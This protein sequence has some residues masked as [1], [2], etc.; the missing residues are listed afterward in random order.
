MKADLK[1]AAYRQ[2]KR[3]LKNRNKKNIAIIFTFFLLLILS[4]LLFI[5]IKNTEEVPSS[6][7]VYTEGVVGSPRFL[8]PIYSEKN[9][10][11]NDLT[12]LLFSGLMTY[13]KENNLKPHL[14]EEVTT[15]DKITFEIKLREDIHWSDGKPITADDVIFTVEKIQDRAIQSPLRVAW[16]GVDA[17]KIDS[18]TI[19]FNL[20]SSSPL[21]FEKLTLKPIPE[22]IWSEVANDDF[23]FS[24][25]N[26]NPV[27]SG[28]YKINNVNQEESTTVS[29]VKN[30]F[31]FDSDPFIDEL[32]FLFFNSEQ[33][34]LENKSEFD[35]FV[36]PSIKSEI[37]GSSLSRYS[38]SLPRYFA[39]FFNLDR[40]DLNTRRALTKSLNIDYLTDSIEDIDSVSSPIIPDFYNL[41]RPENQYEFNQDKALT[42][43][44][45]EGYFLED[46]VLKKRV[47]NENNFE[48]SKRISKD[49]QGEEVRRLQ[50]CLINLTEEGYGDFYQGEVTGYFDDSTEQGV[51]KFQQIFRE[52]IL[53]PHGFQN[54]TGIVAGSTQGK[55]A[56]L[57][58]S[59]TPE[60]ELLKITI[61]TIN[62]PLL[63]ETLENIKEQWS[64]IGV[65]VEIEKVDYSTIEGKILEE[66]N[67]DTFLFG[68][69]MGAIP[70]PYRWWHSS[71]KESPGLNFT[72][73]DNGMADEYLLNAVTAIDETDR[74]TALND[75]QNEIIKDAPAIF[76]YSPQKIYFVSDKVKG[77]SGGKIVNSSQRFQNIN[78]WYINTRR[79]WKKN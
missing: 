76:L 67:F 65:S 7:G 18:R 12:E 25:H 4:A 27:S 52:D 58:D 47:S 46:G 37:N 41:E 28:P 38:Y 53:D 19:E 72:G 33:K 3:F 77:V 45:E 50:D 40:F 16:E 24:N 22:H 10:V 55:L 8:N 20:E 9:E 73:Y 63:L 35:G 13:D 42:L 66:G 69:T 30:E 14:A 54:P 21:F 62:H 6:G 61:T 64:Q 1:I 79:R 70:D 59:S 39:L 56:E 29:L 32:E 78:N 57:C 17:R 51:N 71:Q 48:F 49:D 74:L 60:E 26:L 31:Y 15:E 43:L 44:E 75:F 34:L 36:L 68:V 2:L 23:Q 11:D 5:Y